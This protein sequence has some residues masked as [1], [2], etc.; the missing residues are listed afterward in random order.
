MLVA[1]LSVATAVCAFNWIKYRVC[2]SALLLYM[3]DH[4]YPLPADDDLN[5]HL[6]EAWKHEL[7]IK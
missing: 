3:A 4:E 2:T 7:H 5:E 6:R 1:I